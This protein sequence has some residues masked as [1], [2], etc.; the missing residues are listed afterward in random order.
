MYNRWK[1]ILS[2]PFSFL[3]SFPLHSRSVKASLI[4]LRDHATGEIPAKAETERG[5]KLPSVRDMVMN[6][7]GALLL[8]VVCFSKLSSSRHCFTLA[9]SLLKREMIRSFLLSSFPD[10]GRD[11]WKNLSKR[12]DIF[13]L[14]SRREFFLKTFCFS[15]FTVSS[16]ICVDMSNLELNLAI[17]YIG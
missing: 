7:D 6:S 5:K 3:P 2:F 17:C 10:L 8:R 13:F 9:L 4:Y 12:Q 15:L 11:S 16:T 14:Y 1:Y